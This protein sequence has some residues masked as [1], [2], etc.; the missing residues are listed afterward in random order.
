M[1]PPR[2]LR[3]LVWKLQAATRY[4]W[5]RDPFRDARRIASGR[6]LAIIVDVGA[7][8][9]QSA[10]RLARRFPEGH[11]YSFEPAAS[12]FARLQ[13][14]TQD[15]RR[16]TAI[17]AAVGAQSGQGS[18]TVTEISVLNSLLPITDPLGRDRVV[19]DEIVAI[20]TLDAV[21]AERNLHAIHLL[22]T[23]TQGFDLEVLK[24]ASRLLAENRIWMVHAELLFEEL[25]EN[26]GYFEDLYVFLKAHGFK[27]VSFYNLQHRDE[28]FLWWGDALFYNPAFAV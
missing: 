13:K 18:L 1:K 21:A 25:Y 11:I 6:P 16:I 2:S 27:I 10:K 17:N 7:N 28:P 22:K 9:G 20:T 26:Q 5:G 24:G 8:E 15:E 3:R 14:N 19:G 4:R 12:T 23:D